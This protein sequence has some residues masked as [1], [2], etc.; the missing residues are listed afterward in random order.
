MHLFG[1]NCCNVYSGGK[2]FPQHSDFDETFM[3]IKVR[4]ES[5][6][7]NEHKLLQLSG[8]AL[9]SISG[10]IAMLSFCS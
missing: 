8:K 9:V 7:L 5:R 2:I 1:A 4:Y 10:S 3:C 6:Q